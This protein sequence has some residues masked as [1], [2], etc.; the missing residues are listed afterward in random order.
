MSLTTVRMIPVHQQRYLPSD[1]NKNVDIKYS[2][3]EAFLE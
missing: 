2:M 3:H 1:S